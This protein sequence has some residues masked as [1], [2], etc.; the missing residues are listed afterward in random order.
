MRRCSIVNIPRA[1]ASTVHKRTDPGVE[2]RSTSIMKLGDGFKYG[3]LTAAAAVSGLLLLRTFFG[4]A[5]PMAMELRSNQLVYGYIFAVTIVTVLG[6]SYVL[7]RQTD[8]LR[9][10]STTDSLTGLSN[11]R[12]LEDRLRDEWRRALRYRSPLA[13]LLVDIDGLKRINDRLGHQGGDALLRRTASAIRQSLRTSDI[14]VRWGG[15]EFAILAPHT[16][17]EAA[18]TLAE[19]LLLQLKTRSDAEGISA[20]VGVAT[21]EPDERVMDNPEMLMRAADEALYCAKTAGRDQVHVADHESRRKHASAV[22]TV[23]QESRPVSRSQ[24]W[25]PFLPRTWIHPR[26]R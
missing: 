23:G 9:Q 10:L 25:P 17:R 21:F 4:S 11:R 8:A 3:V 19:R 24:R 1:H 13:L 12:A 2:Y 15:D 5:E 22:A 16:S 6:L 26:Y 7:G 20:S 18:R 14:G